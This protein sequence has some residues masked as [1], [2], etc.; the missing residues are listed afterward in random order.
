V[1]VET[2]EPTPA[3][4]EGMRVHRVPFLAALRAYG[5]EGRMGR[6]RNWT[7]PLLIRHT[8]FHVL[9]HAWEMEDKDLS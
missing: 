2:P 3:S 6:G 8:A 9:D 1:G 5:A 7:I 4:P